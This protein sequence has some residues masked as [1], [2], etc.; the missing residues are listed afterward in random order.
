M[1]VSPRLV[2]NCSYSILNPTDSL[3]VGFFVYQRVYIRYSVADT[4][5]MLT[6]IRDV[7]L[8][9]QSV[10]GGMYN[11]VQMMEL[12]AMRGLPMHQTTIA[13]TIERVMNTV[14][15]V[16]I[17]LLGVSSTTGTASS[18]GSF[19]GSAGRT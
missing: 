8:V 18:A 17:R 10:I 9:T 5:A 6:T 16:V 4:A 2:A 11:R 7:L 19:T 14:L 1:W 12:I 15:A 13:S 3:P